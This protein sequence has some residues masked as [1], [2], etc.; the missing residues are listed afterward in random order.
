MTNIEWHVDHIIPMQGD[1]VCGLHCVDNL[2]VIP[3]IENTQKSNKWN[4][5][6]QK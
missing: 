3:A 6:Q 4:W 1:T 5:D 2:Q